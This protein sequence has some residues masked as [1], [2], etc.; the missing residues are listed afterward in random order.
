MVRIAFDNAPTAEPAAVRDLVAAVLS[1]MH[2]AM[3]ELE[4]GEV[5]RDGSDVVVTVRLDADG[6]DR[7]ASL[8]MPAGY[9]PIE[10]GQPQVAET[11]SEQPSETAPQQTPSLP[12]GTVGSSSPAVVAEASRRY[13]ERL[14]D[15]LDRFERAAEA[16]RPEQRTA[17]WIGRFNN[18]ITRLS[19]KNVD[20]RL[21]AYGREAEDVMRSLAASLKGQKVAVQTAE[22]QLVY[23]YEDEPVY[24]P[25]RYNVFGGFGGLSV[26]VPYGG[27]PVIGGL[28]YGG[29][30]GGN[31]RFTRTP[32]N[33]PVTGFG[34]GPIGPGGPIGGPVTGLGVGPAVVGGVGVPGIGALPPVTQVGTQRRVLD[35]NV[36]TVRREQARAIRKGAEERLE[37]WTEL[38]SQ[39]ND[40]RDELRDDYGAA[41]S[42][43]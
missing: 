6:L 1:E 12:T 7:V 41:W 31:G 5:A 10:P 35:S 40:L 30:V 19:Q 4:A 16:S 38:R 42:G 22:K 25:Y 28:G 29:L 17:A 13:F 18:E 27:N 33:R 32:V 23:R 15:V 34:A 9:Q 26:G 37:A 39:E 8:A 3:P 43:E 2:L 11:K 20:R 36:K 24:A 14:V 21:L